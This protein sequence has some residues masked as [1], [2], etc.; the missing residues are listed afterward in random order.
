[1]ADD[2]AG[3]RF[4]ELVRDVLGPLILGG[5]VNPVRPF[6]PA[7]AFRL[8]EGRSITDSDLRSRLDLARVRRARLIVPVDVLP[9]ISPAEIS[10]AAALNDLLQATN[11]EIGGRFTRG[12]YGRLLLGVGDLCEHIPSPETALEAVARHAT[13]AR[14]LE[15]TRTDTTVSW[16][17]GK[18]SFRGQPPPSRLLAWRSLRR[19][20]VDEHR[21]GLADMCQGFTGA[22]ERGFCDTLGLWLTRSPLTDIATLTR[23]APPFG[24]SPSTLSIIAAP[25]GR[26]LAFRLLTRGG[27]A[28]AVAAA[29]TRAAGEIPAAF[30]REKILAEEFAAEVIAGFKAMEEQRARPEPGSPARQASRT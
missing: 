4:D 10:L 26:T 8:G 27:S 30:G 13:F 28:T 11:H 16:W 1:V 20:N 3:H 29:L 21:V 15:L 7:L 18:A 9:D 5:R 17:T 24:W 12:R 6:G 22:D 2:A 14:V 19:V 25:P 23:R